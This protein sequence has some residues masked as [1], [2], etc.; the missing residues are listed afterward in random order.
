MFRLSTADIKVTRYGYRKAR[1]LGVF[2]TIEGRCSKALIGAELQQ[3][4]VDLDRLAGFTGAQDNHCTYVLTRF[5]RD[6][7]DDVVVENV[8][9]LCF[10]DGLLQIGSDFSPKEW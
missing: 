10:T 8:A 9:V 7:Q 3:F 1:V 6:A 4:Q 5:E 2:M